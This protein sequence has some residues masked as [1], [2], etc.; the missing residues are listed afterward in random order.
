MVSP[1]N[2]CTAALDAL[3]AALKNS[4]RLRIDF[5]VMQSRVMQSCALHE[6]D[7]NCRERLPRHRLVDHNKPRREAHMS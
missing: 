2:R 5:R 1:T 7:C 4:L 3:E 6:G